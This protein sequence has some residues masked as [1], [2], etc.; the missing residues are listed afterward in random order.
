MAAESSTPSRADRWRSGIPAT[1][2]TEDERSYAALLDALTGQLA[3]TVA[4]EVELD[5]TSRRSP[6]DLQEEKERIERDERAESRQELKAFR[7]ALLDAREQSATNPQGEAMYDSAVPQQDDL[8]D[9]L[10]Q[11]LVRPGYAEVRTEEPEPG[12]HVYYLQVAWDRLT[13]LADHD[14]QS[15]SL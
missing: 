14:E 10:I 5:A 6:A 12:H 7:E 13:A 2:W 15:L 4:T 11:Y 1:D 8:A 9:V 3:A